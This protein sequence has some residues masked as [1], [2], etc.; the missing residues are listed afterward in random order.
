MNARDYYWKRVGLRWQVW[1]ELHGHHFRIGDF[2]FWRRRTAARVCNEIFGAY[3]NGRDSVRA[4][5][6]QLHGETK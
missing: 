5:E 3:H 4:S 2:A 1:T 6:Q